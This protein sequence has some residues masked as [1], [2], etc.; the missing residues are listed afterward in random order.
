MHYTYLELIVQQKEKALIKACHVLIQTSLQSIY[1]DIRK[2][3]VQA[4][5]N[6]RKQVIPSHKRLLL[7]VDSIPNSLNMQ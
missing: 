5:N 2:E 3:S 6:D 7:V 4:I 1:R